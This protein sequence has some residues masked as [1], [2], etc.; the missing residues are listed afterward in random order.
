LLIKFQQ[1][2]DG[3]TSYINK[4]KPE[5]DE[6]RILSLLA[7]LYSYC[8]KNA[9]GK[10]ERNKYEGKR[11]LAKTN[12]PQ[13]EWIEYLLK[14]KIE[15]N[16]RSVFSQSISFITAYLDN[17][18][19]EMPMVSINHRNMVAK[20]LLRKSFDGDT[21]VQE[22]LNYFEPYSIAPRNEQNLTRIISEVLY[23][24]PKVKKL[25]FER[26]AGLAV[27]DR[28]G[29][30]DGAIEYLEES[31]YIVFWWNRSPTNRSKVDKLL[32]ET[33]REKGYFYL[34]YFSG[35]EAVYRARVVDF[36]YAD[37]Y[38]GKNWNRNNDVTWYQEDF[39]EYKDDTGKTAKIAFLADE[40]VH[41]ATPIPADRFD[42]YDGEPP[43]HVNLQPYSELDWDENADNP[44]P[45][46]N[47]NVWFVCQ[48][49]AFT[50]EMG[51]KYI[52]APIKD[53][54]GNR[55]YYWDNMANVKKG[56]IIFNYA[57]GLRGV[58]VAT[59]DGY[60]ANNPFADTDWTRDG[61]RVDIALTELS[62]A[63]NYTRL[64]ARKS[65]FEILLRDIQG[66]FNANGDV[67]QGYLFGF[68][69]EAGRLVR[70]I[71]GHDFG[72]T[73]IDE[74]FDEIEVGEPQSVKT[75]TM[76][77][78]DIVEYAHKYMRSKGFQ[79]QPEEVANFYLA[80]KTKPFVILA[81]IS[82]TGKSRLPKMFAKAIGMEDEQV[83]LVPVRPDW[84]DGSELL[85]F[86]GLDNI[87]KPQS[88][89]LAIINAQHNP[90]KPF[91][92]ILDEMNLA[93]VEHYFSDFL[94][95]IET[96]EW[97][98]QRDAIVTQDLLRKE[99]I[100][101]AENA[102]KFENLKWP[103]NLY[104]IG[105]V[106]MDETTHAFSRKVLDR[107]NSIEMNEIDLSWP[108]VAEEMEC[109]ENVGNSFF[110]T[111]YLLANDLNENDR[112]SLEPEMKILKDVNRIMQE[113][114]LHFAYR[115]R[116]EVAFYLHLNKKYSLMP[117]NLAFDFQMMQKVLPR[118]HGSSERI[119]TVLVELLNLLE[120]KKYSSTTFDV[121]KVKD[122]LL[123]KTDLKYRRS[124]KK[125]LFM[126]KRFDEDRFTS[127][128][129]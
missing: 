24:F 62:P 11:V 119:Q 39:A 129:L 49:Q 7:E 13:N 64:R 82:G 56:D 34:Y 40:M 102:S 91:F 76:T 20:C 51:E 21:F 22:V 5:T 118:I 79:Y 2:Q 111:E 45:K 112:N 85:G 89:T 87:F 48:G 101:A 114:D 52:W 37:D 44:N 123:D 9:A 83:P 59:S 81:G 94:S 61:N 19:V 4:L 93:R 73:E 30:Q 54:A 53:Q 100:Q 107:A 32:P 72:N 90:N 17:P 121:K 46:L 66:P 126:L 84:T 74:F 98:D 12:I 96:R 38:P 65:D 106:N 113:A 41:L 6:Y 18:R 57:D 60:K 80:L 77:P 97:T 8:D 58:S 67:K 105:T 35:S 128:W 78:K 124:T 125:I 127:F 29:W 16:D 42:F 33:I 116:D 68:S 99:T 25:W 109:L 31:K 47:R 117:D 43:V 70:D 110:A 26:V 86:T 75:N 103:N 104:L 88:L 95:V 108:N 14:F 92:F 55:W 28:T 120:G 69:R 71:Y 36:A 63:I 115:V 15:N 1:S 122:E 3:F 10:A 23:R 27:L 50:P